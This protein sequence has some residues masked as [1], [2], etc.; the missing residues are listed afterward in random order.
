MPPWMGTD[1]EAV[2]IAAHIHNQIDQR[3]MHQIYGLQGVE[4]GKKVFD[5]RCGVCHAFG[6]PSDKTESLTGLTEDDYSNLLDIAADLGEGMPPFNAD[7]TDRAALIAFLKT[8]G[9]GDTHA[10]TGL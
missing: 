5:V 4:L 9:Q 6:G 8:L 3:P 10:A 2:A 7:D 1:D